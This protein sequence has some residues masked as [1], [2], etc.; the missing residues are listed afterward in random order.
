MCRAQLVPTG[1]VRAV[2][3]EAAA[4]LFFG[5]GADQVRGGQP[6]PPVT[7]DSDMLV[8]EIQRKAP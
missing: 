5:R 1:T 4:P 7:D 6:E 2:V 8:V 3:D